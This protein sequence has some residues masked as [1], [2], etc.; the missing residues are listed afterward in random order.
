MG[1]KIWAFIAFN[2]Y[3]FFLISAFQENTAYLF[4]ASLI[5]EMR[6][7]GLSVD[8]RQWGWGN[9]YIW[10]I[11]AGVI[12]TAVAGF[13]AGAISKAKGAVTAA[14]SNIPSI[15]VWA[16]M[17]YFFGF[18]NVEVEG[19]TGF[20][21]ISVIAIPLTTYI[22]YLAGNFGEEIQREEFSDDTV[23][24]VKPYH[25]IW[26]IFPLY[27]YS[28]GIVFVA[29]K[30]IAFQLATWGDTSI[31]VS[32]LSLLALIPIIAWIY[33][34]RLVHRV[35]MGELL[36]AQNAVIRG[37]ANFGILILG[38]GA[39]TVLQMGSYWLLAKMAS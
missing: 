10:R 19:K 26:S 31:F 8:P 12:V 14:T 20:I 27:W 9:H 34:L 33:P 18:S 25:W 2:C 30:F 4:D 15:I 38:M 6:L 32:I 22:A 11:I 21:V 36:S 5:K 1:R 16:L 7:S 28:L 39:A 35:L 37:M 29:T 23:L 24:G 17:V 13:L 3:S